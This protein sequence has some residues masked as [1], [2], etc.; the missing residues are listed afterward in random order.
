MTKEFM[1]M[2]SSFP[3]QVAPFKR[4]KIVT[5]TSSVPKSASGKLLRRELIAQVRAKM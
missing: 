4:L 5:F 2:I 3:L 1:K